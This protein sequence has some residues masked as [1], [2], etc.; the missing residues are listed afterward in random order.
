MAPKGAVFTCNFTAV[1]T[2]QRCLPATVRMLGLSILLVPEPGELIQVA[3]YVF[4][5]GTTH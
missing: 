4:V 3:E 5:Q 1:E 2:V